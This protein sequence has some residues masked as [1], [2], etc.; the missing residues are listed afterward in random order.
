MQNESPRYNLGQRHYKQSKQITRSIE[1]SSNP[2]ESHT[3]LLSEGILG[4]ESRKSRFV[5]SDHP[6]RRFE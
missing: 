2:Q 5:A 3:A 1:S 6:K 4:Q